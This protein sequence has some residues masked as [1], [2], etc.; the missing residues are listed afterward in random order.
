MGSAVDTLNF[1]VEQGNVLET[2]DEPS[3]DHPSLPSIAQ[4]GPQRTA[5][6]TSNCNYNSWYTWNGMAFA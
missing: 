5:A 1:V 6:A 3:A 2:M 4:R